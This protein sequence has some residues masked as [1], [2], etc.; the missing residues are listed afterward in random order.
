[1]IGAVVHIRL[2][3][4]RVA[5][6]ATVTDEDE[7]RIR[8]R[9]SLDSNSSPG[10]WWNRSELEIIRVESEPEPWQPEQPADPEEVA[11]TDRRL[12]DRG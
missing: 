4:R 8:L 7:N 5:L 1:M 6:R 12:G 3:S 11:E 9:T 2:P 10:T